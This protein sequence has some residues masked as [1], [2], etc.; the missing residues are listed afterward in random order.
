MEDG[1]EL[2][3][4]QRGHSLQVEQ[5]HYAPEVNHLPAMSSDLLLRFGR[6][7]DAWWGVGGFTGVPLLL[8]LCW[9]GLTEEPRKRGS[10]PSTATSG[11]L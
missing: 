1:L 11:P 8:P 9:R 4:A 10:A 7:S 2:L 6:I 3:S 5:V